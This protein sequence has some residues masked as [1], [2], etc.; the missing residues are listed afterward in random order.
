MKG[1]ELWDT[2]TKFKEQMFSR[3]HTS[4]SPW[5]IVKTNNKKVARRETM[6]HVL[7][8][9]DYPEKNKAK[10]NLYPDPN[11]IVRYYRHLKQIDN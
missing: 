11:V 1:Q 6:R 8:Q 10:I 5:I 9:F 2:Y 4:F 3:T 7:S